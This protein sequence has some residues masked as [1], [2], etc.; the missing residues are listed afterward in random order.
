MPVAAMRQ[1][2]Q[3]IAHVCDCDVTVL[4]RGERGVGKVVVVREIHDRPRAA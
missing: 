1:V 2:A 4:I 3:S